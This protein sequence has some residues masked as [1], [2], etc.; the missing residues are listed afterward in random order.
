MNVYATSSCGSHEKNSAMTTVSSLYYHHHKHHPDSWGMNVLSLP[1]GIEW[2]GYI[3]PFY[4]PH[5]DMRN[6]KPLI[7]WKYIFKN[8]LNLPNPKFTVDYSTFIVN[9]K[10]SKDYKALEKIYSIKIW[11]TSISSYISV[12]YRSG[13][14]NRFIVDRMEEDM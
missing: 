12:I 6:F 4:F 8:W 7:I 3:V 5:V 13:Q 1:A 9:I 14:K 10:I 2:C 11:N